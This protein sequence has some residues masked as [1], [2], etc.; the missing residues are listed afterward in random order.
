METQQQGKSPEMTF[1]FRRFCCR[2]VL[3]PL[4]TFFIQQTKEHISFITLLFL[5]IHLLP[6]LIEITIMQYDNVQLVLKRN[7]VRA[8]I[9]DSSKW[10]NTSSTVFLL[11]TRFTRVC[12]RRQ[13]ADNMEIQTLWWILSPAVLQRLSRSEGSG[14]VWAH[15]W[16]HMRPF[17]KRNSSL[18]LKHINLSPALL[19][20]KI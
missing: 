11:L 15:W 5:I 12:S 9:S 20:L 7:T 4:E 10:R 17:W 16:G 14:S 19:L 8:S 6:V 1:Y 13:T 3:R 18:K 2:N